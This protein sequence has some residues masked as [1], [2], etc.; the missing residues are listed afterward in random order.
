MPLS[1]VCDLGIKPF[2][3]SNYTKVMMDFD[4][5]NVRSIRHRIRQTTRLTAEWTSKIG[6]KLLL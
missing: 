1:V 5:R 4:P 2:N 3:D 6:N